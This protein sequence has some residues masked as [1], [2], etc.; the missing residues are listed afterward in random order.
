MTVD[1]YDP[2]AFRRDGHV[3]ID[4]LADYLNGT[5]NGEGPVLDYVAPSE[6][7]ERWTADFPAE[8]T[9]RLPD[10]TRR[11]ISESHHLHHPRYIG[12]QVSA[13]LPTSALG[14]LVSAL[15]NNGMAEYEMGPVAN[16]MEQRVIEWFGAAL[17]FGEAVGGLLTS[18][19]SL[20]N[21]TAL[22]AARQ[23]VADTNI[24]HDGVAGAVPLAIL[25]SSQAH[26]SNDRAA[27]ILGLGAGGVIGVA[28]DDQM[29]L[30]PGGIAVAHREAERNG[31]RVFAIVG[32]ACATATGAFDPLDAIADYAEAHGLWFHVD[33]AHAAVAALS[34]RYRHLVEGIERADSVI[35]DAHKMLQM[36]ALITAL[37]FKRRE[38]AS[39]AFHQE[40]SYINFRDEG[41]DYP[42]WDSGLRTLECTKRMM[43]LELY[44]TLREHGTAR[45]RR[46]VEKTFDLGR[47]FAEIVQAETDFECPVEPQANIV[48]FRY[49]PAGVDELDELQVRVRAALVESGD[50][51]VVKTRL[52]DGI[53]LRITV[54]NA[55]TTEEDLR[56][57]LAAVREAARGVQKFGPR[58]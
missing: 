7:L 52:P 33:G 38:A 1:P 11:V 53:Y 46:H 47:R 5:A 45:F 26:Y 27:R 41:D 50:F 57:L 8:P 29:R 10:L 9:E 55:R 30:D 12:H 4:L 15:L 6:L 34:P 13:P 24:W 22:A 40:Q 20:G 17:G 48:C 37:L 28:T 43:S 35:I 56:D 42:W 14:E 21:L 49:A 39:L 16:V 2:E 25:V 54:M 32:S 18:G 23:S 58:P 19:G 3:V 44:A 36:P 51:Y 31:R